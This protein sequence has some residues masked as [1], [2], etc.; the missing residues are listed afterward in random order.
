MFLR[1]GRVIARGSVF[2]SEPL[3]SLFRGGGAFAARE[4]R[5][6]RSAAGGSGRLGLGGGPLVARASRRALG[7]HRAR[8][9]VQAAHLDLD[10]AVH[11]RLHGRGGGRHL[12]LR[13]RPRRRPRRIRGRIRGRVRARPLAL[14]QRGVVQERRGGGLDRV[15][16]EGAHHGR[17]LVDRAVRGHGS[18]P[19]GFHRIHR[20]VPRRDGAQRGGGRDLGARRVARARGD[21]D[22]S[23]RADA[24]EDQRDRDAADEPRGGDS[25]AVGASKRRF[26]GRRREVARE[27]GRALRAWGVRARGRHFVRL[28]R[29]AAIVDAGASRGA[30]T[31]VRARPRIRRV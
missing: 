5:R 15:L 2:I 26:H 28:T 19:G 12:R 8:S 14:T 10:L 17:V 1:G 16:A 13:I 11:V 31:L 4:L 9:L 7:V 27:Q 6:V 23:E 22:A 25:I 3:R 30:R 21:R 20:R 18:R 29:L 24:R